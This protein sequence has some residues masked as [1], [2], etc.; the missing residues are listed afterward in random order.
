M[1]LAGTRVRVLLGFGE[2][3]DWCA[4]GVDAIEDGG[5]FIAVADKNADVRAV[6]SCASGRGLD[7][8]RA[9]PRGR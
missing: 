5:P 4:A 6:R 1:K 3:E 7:G 8:W 9:V 2:A